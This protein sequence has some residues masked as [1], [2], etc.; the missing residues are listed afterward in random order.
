MWLDRFSGHSTPSGSPPRTRSYSPAP[1]RSS[2][3]APASQPF[4]PG[5]SPRSS[6]LSLASNAS[7]SSLPGTRGQA[8]GSALKQSVVSSPPDE[9]SNPLDVLRN[10]VG[11]SLKTGPRA[12]EDSRNDLDD[13]LAA[14]VVDGVDFGGLSLQEF[15]QAQHDVGKANSASATGQMVQP[16]EEYEKERDKFEDLHRSILGCDEVLQS[17]ETY[18]TSFQTDLGAVSAEIESL[19]SRST[20]LNGRLDNRKTVESLLGPIVE[21]FSTSPS[22]IKKISEGPI[23]NAWMVALAQVDR[24][25]QVIE[26][27]SKAQDKAKAVDDIKPLMDDL[28]NKAIERIRDFMIE[29]IKSLRSPN[30]NAQIIQ[31]QSF[32]RYKDLFAF[33]AKHHSQLA[34]EIGQAYINT[35]RW[36]YL[37]LF[38]RYQ[39][40]LEHLRLHVLDKNDLLGQDDAVRKEASIMSSSKAIAPAHDALTLGRRMDVLKTSNQ[41]AISSYVAEEDKST[42]YLEVPFRNFNLALIDNASAEYSFLTKFFAPWSFHQISRKF[43]EIFEP[44]FALGQTLTK[45]LIEST[46]D[47][48]GLLICVRLN[49]HFAFELQRRKMPSMDGYVN[50][51]NIQLWPRFQ[52]VM[53]MHCDS[54]KRA[55]AAISTGRGGTSALS[56]TAIDSSKQSAAP[57]PIAQRFGHFLQG[58]ISLSSDAGDDE[59]VSNSL[60]RVRREI[61]AFLTKMGK[62]IGDARKRERFLFNNYSLICTIISDGEGKFAEDQIEHF[63]SMK[64]AHQESE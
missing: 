33:L 2:H 1:Q 9:V 38:T 60:N 8:N 28:I 58:I 20:A 34:E 18:L 55:T 61:D 16:S 15:A 44:T 57:H 59:P 5:Y 30:I 56:L 31:Q 41:S 43:T 4:R 7:T 63:E 53:D 26:A 32:L 52:L 54:V 23:D 29:H 37:N 36:Y 46:V 13:P 62:S 27:K 48:L 64:Q 25:S 40:A 22:V 11:A 17:V 14:S 42:H 35:M 21:D 24:R 39:K 6:S 47:G 19:Q 3:L 45:S 51:T 50:G 49:Q 10:I 12:S